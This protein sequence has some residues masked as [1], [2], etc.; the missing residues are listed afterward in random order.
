M[1]LCGCGTIFS[2]TGQKP[3]HKCM[4]CRKRGR[5]TPQSASDPNLS[6][7]RSQAG[8]DTHLLGV[9]LADLPSVQEVFDHPLTTALRI[10]G[11]L[12]NRWKKIFAKLCSNATHHGDL[13]HHLLLAMFNQAGLCVMPRGG[14]KHNPLNF[15]SKQLD[16][17]ESDPLGLWRRLKA[18]QRPPSRK[19]RNGA[20]PRSK[21]AIAAARRGEASRAM[22]SLESGAL[23]PVDNKTLEALKSKHPQLCAPLPVSAPTD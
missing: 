13:R 10:P 1:K 5:D 6:L 14:K 19:V 3:H 16:E 22:G 7:P 8:R 11:P 18:R 15:Y 2:N 12:R 21:A 4:P 17:W 9:T 23:A 20:L